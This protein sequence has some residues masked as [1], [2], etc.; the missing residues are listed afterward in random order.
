MCQFMA[1]CPLGRYLTLTAQCNSILSSSIAGTPD[2]VER[3]KKYLGEMVKG[4]VK[5]NQ[6]KH[7][8]SLII[9]HIHKL[10]CQ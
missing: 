6:S 7:H 4:M 5:K 2:N 8:N 3:I 1:K 9:T 10:D